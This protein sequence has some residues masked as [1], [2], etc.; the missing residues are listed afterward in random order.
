MS[1][2][3]D[4]TIFPAFSARLRTKNSVNNY[5][6][7]IREF[8]NFTGVSFE[9]ANNRQVAEY[10]LY[11]TK[12]EKNDNKIK[13]STHATK[14]SMLKSIA[15]F[16]ENCSLVDNYN[17]PFKDIHIERPDIVLYDADV[18]LLH[19]LEVLLENAKNNPRDFLIFLLAAKCG[20]TTG[21]LLNLRLK[22]LIF[23]ENKMVYS[24][25]ILKGKRQRNILIPEDVSLAFQNYLLIFE[26]EDR[27]FLNSRNKP[28]TEKGLQRLIAS[29]MDNLTEQLSGRRMTLADLRHSAIKYMKMGGASNTEI[30]AYIGNE[31]AYMLSR[32][33]NVSYNNME[34][35]IKYSVLSIN[36]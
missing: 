20:L 29:Y 3:F 28:I 21:E 35:G 36:N 9:L 19:D 27:L 7:T 25:N 15:D 8:N 11:L 34:K 26:G 4:K 5:I 1:E 13:A 22:D 33:D 16:I 14:L 17:N 32:Y 24:I 12:L 6:S 30:A 18:P 2:F 23:D 31:K 10:D